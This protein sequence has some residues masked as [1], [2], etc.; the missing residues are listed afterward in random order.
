MNSL[1][2]KEERQDP[3]VRLADAAASVRLL[4]DDQA[5]VHLP[6]RGRSRVCVIPL[7]RVWSLLALM[8]CCTFVAPGAGAAAAH[9]RCSL[10]PGRRMAE[11]SA[12]H[13]RVAA[14]PQQSVS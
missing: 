9:V 12:S 13:G 11:A 4:T 10:P 5:Q 14:K 2:L 1:S 3:L 8:C 7:L 6:C